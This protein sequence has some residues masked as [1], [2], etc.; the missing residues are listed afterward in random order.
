MVGAVRTSCSGWILQ[1]LSTEDSVCFNTG[2]VAHSGGPL[3][4]RTSRETLLKWRSE[5]PRPLKGNGI[6][7]LMRKGTLHPPPIYPLLHTR[8][9]TSM[10]GPYCCDLQGTQ[11]FHETLLSRYSRAPTWKHL[12][13]SCTLLSSPPSASFVAMGPLTN[14]SGNQ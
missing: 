2:S 13:T 6:L 9:Q 1:V 14:N 5:V 12:F 11:V 10:I 3:T 7:R 8:V 4:G